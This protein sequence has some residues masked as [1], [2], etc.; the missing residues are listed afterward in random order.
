[1][2]TTVLDNQ[3]TCNERVESEKYKMKNSC[4]QMGSQS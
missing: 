3:T 1:M 2:Q 4:P